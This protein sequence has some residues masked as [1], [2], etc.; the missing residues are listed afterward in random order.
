MP[1]KKRVTKDNSTFSNIH[2]HLKNAHKQ[3]KHNFNKH[4]TNNF[5]KHITHH[6][7]HHSNKIHKHLIHHYQRRKHIE[8]DELPK[9]K[10]TVLEFNHKYF[11]WLEHIVEH[12]IP[13]LVLILLFIIIAEFGNEINRFIE[14]LFNRSFH[15]LAEV[16]EIAEK[17]HAT[18]LAMDK[19]IISFFVVDLYFNF[20]KK[21]TLKSFFRTYFIDVIAVLPLGL[22]LEAVAREIGGAQSVT[23]VAVDTERIAVRAAKT[24]RIIKLIRAIARLSRA[25]RLYRLY[26]FFVSDNSDNLNKLNN[27]KNTFNKQKHINKKRYAKKEN[28]DYKKK[29]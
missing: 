26:Y 28:K 14:F 11:H 17:N 20:F 8:L 21:A 1:N 3:V 4:I 25:I 29:K 6:I 16:A 5:N 10:R 18:I 9:W 15:A 2:H 22:A 19:V 7:K 13:W 12:A 27:P 24:T 23:H